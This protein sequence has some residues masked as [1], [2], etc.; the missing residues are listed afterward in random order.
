MNQQIK[1]HIMTKVTTQEIYDLANEFTLQQV[2]NIV[3]GWEARNQMAVLK[4]YKSLVRLGDSEQ[5]ACATMIAEQMNRPW[6]FDGSVS[7]LE[8]LHYS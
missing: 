7:E 5:L 6:M 4:S 8:S 1:H 2:S 3:D